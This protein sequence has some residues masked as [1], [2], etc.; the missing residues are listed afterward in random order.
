MDPWDDLL[1][2]IKR[3]GDELLLETR[4]SWHKPW[5]ALIGY[6]DCAKALGIK[7]DPISLWANMP[8]VCGFAGSGRALVFDEAAVLCGLVKSK[9]EVGRLLKGGAKMWLDGR[10]VKNPKSPLPDERIVLVQ[11]GKTEARC[12]VEPIYG[13]WLRQIP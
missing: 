5:A 7:Q 4:L 11:T 6:E 8:F 2:R 3:Q 10:P 12:V 13:Y 1:L 9:G